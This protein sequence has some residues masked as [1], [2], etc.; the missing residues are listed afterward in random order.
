MRSAI[1]PATSAL[2][3]RCVFEGCDYVVV[4]SGSCTGMIRVHFPEVFKDEPFLLGKAEHLA[5]RAF[6]IRAIRPC[7]N[8]TRGRR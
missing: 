8:G 6:E 5:A 1:P 3:M 2:R 4:P 7:G